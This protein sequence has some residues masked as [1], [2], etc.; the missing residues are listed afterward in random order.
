MSGTVPG[1][2]APIANLLAQFPDNISG[3]ILPVN[4]R[5]VIN[6]LGA[7]HLF[8][9]QAYGIITDGGSFGDGLH[10][11]ASSNGFPTLGA[12][13]A[14]YPFATDTSNDMAGLM[15][16]AAINAAHASGGGTVLLPPGKFFNL[17]TGLVFAANTKAKLLGSGGGNVIPGYGTII[18]CSPCGTNPGITINAQGNTEGPIRNIVLWGLDS[19]TFSPGNT[20]G[21]AA[22]NTFTTGSV[23]IFFV[24]NANV[25]YHGIT[26]VNFDIT[27]LWDTVTGG[28]HTITF[29]DGIVNYCNKGAVINTTSPNSFEKMMWENYLFAGNNY[30]AYIILQTS[31]TPGSGS[32]IISDV[33]FHNCSF[34]YNIVNQLYYLGA[35][36]GGDA[37]NSVYFNQCHI[38]AGS[39]TSGTGARMLHDGNLSLSQC[40]CY[41]NGPSMPVGLISPLS[42]KSRTSVVNTKGPGLNTSDATAVPIIKDTL[43]NLFNFGYAN[44]AR[45]SGNTLLLATTTGNVSG[46]DPAWYPRNRVGVIGNITLALIDSRPAFGC[47]TVIANTTITVPPD[48]TSNFIVGTVMEFLTAPSFTGTFVAGSGVTINGPLA[49]GSSSTS[50]VARA[51]LEKTAS[52]TWSTMVSQSGSGTATAVAGAATLNTPSGIVTSEALTGATAYTLT[53]TNS[54]ITANSVVLT[55]PVDSAGGA[56]TLTSVT[57]SAGSVVIVVAMPSLTGTVQFPFHVF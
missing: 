14:T 43:G 27:T 36:Y 9:P 48:S 25:N 39:T 45:I 22:T 54:L 28:N 1:L 57:P 56:V 32:G 42:T 30:G 55:T 16:Q 5:S 40:E 44:T 24:S 53:L 31:P 34:D 37:T 8:P 35:A 50:V 10:H 6:T 18:L 51:Q 19:F 15:I 33:Y 4:E 7:Q 11:P 21:T 17:P 41:E 52:N 3:L 47:H 26:F 20:G 23:G 38:E 13:H 46:F 49:F 2:A 29:R 12:L